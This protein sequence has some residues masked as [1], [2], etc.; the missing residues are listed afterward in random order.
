MQNPPP[1]LQKLMETVLFISN[2]TLADMLGLEGSI[3]IEVKFKHDSKWWMYYQELLF[4]KKQHS[5]CLVPNGY[6]TKT[7]LNLGSWVRNQRTAKKAGTLDASREELL[8]MAGF[9]WEARGYTWFVYLAELEYYYFQHG[10][11]LVPNR[12]LT[13]TGWNLDFWVS[14]QRTLK[15]TRKLD[16]SREEL[17]D[18]TGFVWET[19]G[20][21]WFL[22]LAELEYYYFQHGDCLVPTGYK[23][24]TGLNLGSWVNNQRTS[25]KAGTLEAGREE[26]LTMTG[27]VWNALS[28][29]GISLSQRQT[30]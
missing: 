16:A 17:L 6:K 18:M 29:R 20:Y 10:N 11:C 23:T 30:L 2:T 15:K 7:G 27:F 26:L 5:D 25:K 14:T 28:F 12:Y 3:A 4:Y 19:R 8:T 21:T 9:V 24:K 13:K 1:H 22:H